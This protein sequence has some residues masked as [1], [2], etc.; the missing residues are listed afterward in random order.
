MACSGHTWLVLMGFMEQLSVATGLC[1]HSLDDVW[2]QRAQQ[3]EKTKHQ[4]RRGLGWAS[5][6][7]Q[8]GVWTFSASLGLPPWVLELRSQIHSGSK[9]LPQAVRRLRTSSHNPECPCWG[10]S[11]PWGSRWIRE[12][13]RGLSGSD[14]SRFMRIM[15][16]ICSRSFCLKSAH[17][18][19][20][21][22]GRVVI[23]DCS[24]ASLDHTVSL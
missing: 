18:F 12:S 5:R 15:N 3:A 17:F 9:K 2:L 11:G 20:D 22:N 1:T 19:A 7:A 6:G 23:T 8:T 4:N 16:K 14:I 21:L 13:W 10:R 24:Q